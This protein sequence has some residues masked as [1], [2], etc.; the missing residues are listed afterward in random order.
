MSSRDFA[1][2]AA[3]AIAALGD[4]SPADAR[5]VLQ[6]YDSLDQIAAVASL[7]VTAQTVGSAGAARAFGPFTFAFDTPGLNNGVEFYTP[8][9]GDILLDAFVIV[10]QAFDGTTPKFDCVDLY[11]DTN[12][13]F[14][15]QNAP[16]DATQASSTGSGLL[17]FG[18]V[19]SSL[20]AALLTYAVPL[21]LPFAPVMAKVVHPTPW[22]LWVSSDGRSGGVAAGSTQGAGELYLV[23]S[24]P[25]VP[26]SG[27]AA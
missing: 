14:Y 3:D 23:M 25:T 2:A 8:A 19:A 24:T 10:T 5:R 16:V 4:A 6:E 7:A 15:N 9:V 27:V 20:T 18:R 11:G 26:G 1:Q 21:A 17:L 13:M 12:G 22:K